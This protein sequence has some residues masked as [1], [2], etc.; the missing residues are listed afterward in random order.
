MDDF[1]RSF[2]ALAAQHYPGFR[3]D[4]EST[5]QDDIIAWANKMRRVLNLAADDIG[6]LLNIVETLSGEQFDRS[7]RKYAETRSRMK[8]L[9]SSLSADEQEAIYWI[10][11]TEHGT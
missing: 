7:G 5:D 2:A 4:A 6:N 8:L 11:E 9:L 1:M 3:K 10:L